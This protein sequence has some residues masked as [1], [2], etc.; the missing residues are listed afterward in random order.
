MISYKKSVKVYIQEDGKKLFIF[1]GSKFLLMLNE[2]KTLI[3]I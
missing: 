2:E 3:Y 1:N